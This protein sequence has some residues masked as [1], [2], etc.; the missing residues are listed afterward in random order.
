LLSLPGVG[1]GVLPAGTYELQKKRKRKEEE[2][3]GSLLLM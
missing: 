2:G 1:I 3:C